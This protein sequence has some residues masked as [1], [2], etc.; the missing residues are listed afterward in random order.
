MGAPTAPN[1]TDGPREA[2]VIVVGNEKGGAGKSTV[3]I[4]LCV[5]LMRTGHRVGVVDLDVR[6]RT[7]TRY[8][9]N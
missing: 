1:I 5:A 8:L 7:L 6:Q 3:S 9:E 2:R 4:H